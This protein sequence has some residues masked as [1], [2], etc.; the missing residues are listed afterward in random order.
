MASNP[1]SE[2]MLSN[3]ERIFLNLF[4]EFHGKKPYIQDAFELRLGVLKSDAQYQYMKDKLKN[5]L[6]FRDI[7]S[8]A[9]ISRAFN[10]DDILNSLLDMQF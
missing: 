9:L 10:R 4:S 8:A 5:K 6:P 3:E 1:L 2:V 7:E